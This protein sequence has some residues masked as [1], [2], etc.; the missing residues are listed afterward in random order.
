MEPVVNSI[1]SVFLMR[2]NAP[3][4]LKILDAPHFQVSSLIRGQ[5][6][7]ASPLVRGSAIPKQ[8]STAM[9]SHTNPSVRSVRNPAVFDGK[10]RILPRGALFEASTG[11]DASAGY[12]QGAGLIK[13]GDNSGWA[14]VPHQED[15]DKQYRT[16]QGGAKSTETGNSIA[17]AYEE[18]GNAIQDESSLSE[19]QHRRPS[20]EGATTKIWLRVASR[21]GIL[22]SCTPPPSMNDPSNVSPTLSKADSSDVA[23]SVAS[24]FLDGMFR[25]PKKIEQDRGIDTGRETSLQTMKSGNDPKQMPHVIQCGMCIQIDRFVGNPDYV[26]LSGGQG[27]IPRQVNG[28]DCTVTGQ[29]PETRY[30]S[31]WFRVEPQRGVKVRLG[32]SRKATSIKSETG[33]YFRFECGE[34][35]R[36]CEVMTVCD[37]NGASESFA[38]LYRNRHAELLRYDNKEHRLLAS[39]TSTAEWV[40]IHS[41]DQTVYLEECVSP[42]H[43]QRHKKGWRYNAV[44]DAGVEVRKGPSFDSEVTGLV[45]L[46]GES[47]MV[48]ERVTGPSERITWLRLSDSQGWVHDTGQDGDVT[49]IAHSLEHRKVG[50]LS[51]T[52]RPQNGGGAGEEEVAYNTIIARLF[53]GEG[54]EMEEISKPKIDF[55]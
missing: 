35:L 42:P 39:L 7:A 52:C 11:M 36:A 9:F 26:R 40:Q 5:T 49:M 12:S 10:K 6:R 18:V 45:L 44:A 4:G 2:V 51:Q 23:S 46:G 48:N 3:K 21:S 13:L 27:W 8:P 33:L 29:R 32:P 53:H 19:S 24:A 54:D 17:R 16:F 30:G 1:P 50:L 47:V 38:K 43:I 37:E 41:A 31:F 20:N 15:L 14:V 25:T 34:Y 55:K 22:V 28:R